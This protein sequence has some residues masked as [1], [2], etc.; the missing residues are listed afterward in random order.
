MGK[1]VDAIL[2]PN[3][4]EEMLRLAFANKQFAELVV[5]NL[6]LSNFPRELGGCKA[7]LKVLADTMKKTGN[8]ATFG[9]VE[10]T[11]PNNEEVSKK[12]AEVKGLIPLSSAIVFETS[13]VVGQVISTIPNFAR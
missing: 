13:S 11:F 5:D 2:S 8:L 6:D 7:M 3:F 9:M 10:M 4:V 1:K 12:I